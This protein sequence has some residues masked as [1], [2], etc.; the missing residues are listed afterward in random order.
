MPLLDP[1]LLLL[2]Q[3]AKHLAEMWTQRPVECLS[4][5]LRDE[6]DVVF[7]CPLGLLLTPGLDR[8]F[9]CQINQLGQFFADPAVIV[10]V[11]AVPVLAAT[12][13]GLMPRITR[14]YYFDRKLRSRALKILTGVK[15]HSSA[16]LLV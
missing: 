11:A 13:S 15:F 1:A 4:T 10:I 14:P 7:A 12:A 2:R 9:F 16:K 3:G 5:P 8:D 6:N